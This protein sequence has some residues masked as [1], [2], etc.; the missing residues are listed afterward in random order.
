MAS[1]SEE[2]D[3]SIYAEGSVY[4]KKMEAE[5]IKA[6][7]TLLVPDS[8]D[9]TT[10]VDITDLLQDFNDRNEKHKGDIEINKLDISL[11]KSEI[12]T[13]KSRVPTLESDMSSL[14]SSVS[15]IHSDTWSNTYDIS[16]IHNLINDLTSRIS[17]LESP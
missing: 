13:L 7:K 8:K 12:T 17:A 4:T 3:G 9:R 11:N 2:L 10:L 6:K 1:V 16:D 15:D 14:S 5:E